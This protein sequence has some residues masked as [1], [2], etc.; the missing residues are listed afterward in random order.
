MGMAMK[1]NDRQSNTNPTV[2]GTVPVEVVP[3]TLVLY[4]ILPIAET[5]PKIH[6]NKPGQPHSN[7]DATVATMPFV[8]LS[9]FSSP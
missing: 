7:T 8:L 9:I 4:G 5:A 2:G 3:F 6:R 1:I